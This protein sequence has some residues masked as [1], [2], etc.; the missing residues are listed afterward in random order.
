[1]RGSGVRVLVALA[2]VLLGCLL[3]VRS[4]RLP[5]LAEPPGSRAI[6]DIGDTRLGRTLS[7]QVAANPGL[8]GV[9]PIRDGHDA[10]ADRVLLAEA[11]DRS[12]DVQYYIWRPDMSG[13]LLAEALH[14]AAERGVRVR[15]LL[16]DNNTVGLDPMLAALDAHENIEVRL[17]NP[18][19][20]RGHRIL[21][22]L[23]DFDRLNRRMHNKSFT[24]D[25]QATIVGGRNVGNEY[26]SVGQAMRYIDLDVLAVGPVARAVSADFERYWSSRSSYPLRQVLGDAASVDPGAVP[27]RAS[28]AERD[29][30]ARAYLDAVRQSG[31]LRSLLAGEISF[32]WTRVRLFSDDPAKGL[33]RGA[34]E[35]LLSERLRRVLGGAEQE[36]ELV[37]P[38]FVPTKA[39]VRA[40]SDLVARGVEVGV[41]TNSLEATDVIPVHAGYARHRV[42]LLEAGV[43]LYELKREAGADPR[44]VH[45]LAGSSASSLHAKVFSVDR[46]R[47]FVGSFNFDPR[48]ANLNT[49]MGLLID[50]PALARAMVEGMRS[51]LPGLAYEVTLGEDGKPR[52]IERRDSGA[53]APGAETIVHRHEPDAGLW[54]RLGV[55][56]TSRLPVEWLL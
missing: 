10:F 25:N 21:G 37:T 4:I 9:W 19:P 15:L 1:M 2:I 44:D 40:L 34:R 22:Y 48:S 47:L 56:L 30:H 36:V 39:G 43:R 18:F 53:G 8:S 55:W 3:L 6:V 52:W 29:P 17:F 49:E 5:P 41:L 31:F 24:A 51:V 7:G 20:I 54:S 35:D 50:S 28:L 12:L 26:F 46:Q 33:G 23:T 27:R 11:A 45:R 16:D 14:R 42:A 32:E 38:Y 13:V